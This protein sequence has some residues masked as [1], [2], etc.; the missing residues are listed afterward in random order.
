MLAGLIYLL[1]YLVGLLIAGKGQMIRFTLISLFTYLISVGGLYF[2]SLM[3]DAGIV[4]FFLPFSLL[5]VAGFL[6]FQKR[7]LKP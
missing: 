1:P 6:R 3:N 4:L 7:R 5:I 2:T